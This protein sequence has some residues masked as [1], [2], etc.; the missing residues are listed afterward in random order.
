MPIKA[1][2]NLNFPEKLLGHDSPFGGGLRGR[3]IHVFFLKLLKGLVPL[4]IVVVK[5]RKY[6]V[7]C[8]QFFRAD[9]HYSFIKLVSYTLLKLF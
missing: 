6:S 1:D 2:W 4:F 5:C 7:I 8:S 3:T 9:E